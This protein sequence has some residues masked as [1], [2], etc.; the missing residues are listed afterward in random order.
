MHKKR[1]LI[2]K[3]KN[4]KIIL[5]IFL[6][7]FGLVWFIIPSRAATKTKSITPLEDTYTDSASPTTSYGSEGFM[8]SYYGPGINCSAY[9]QFEL[10][11]LPS[12]IQTV[13]LRYQV[14][15]LEASMDL[16]FFNVGDIWFE[17]FLT[18]NTRPTR[19]ELLTSSI[20]SSTGVKIVEFPASLDLTSE[21]YFFSV[22]LYPT[23]PDDLFVVIATKENTGGY[24][25][26]TLLIEYAV[27]E[28]SPFPV[29]LVVGIIV[30][31]SAAI[32][33]AAIVTII[34]VKKKKGRI[35]PI[36]E[37]VQKITEIK[38]QPVLEQ[39][40]CF[41]CGSKVSGKFCT[42]CGTEVPL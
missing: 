1:G 38:E 33:T 36:V 42:K 10:S 4:K 20:I 31:V 6:I 40:F 28:P 9:I 34:L 3:M 41:N 21:W 12:N 26:P 37:P 8:V 7:F 39:K 24:Q 23:S 15:Y 30:G 14:T 13:S 2:I 32:A 17:D 16:D 35:E 19:I 22:E 5:I 11:D 27:S 18:H 29:G 25:V